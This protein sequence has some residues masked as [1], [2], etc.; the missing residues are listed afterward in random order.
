MIIYVLFKVNYTHRRCNR[1]NLVTAKM[2][3]S[4]EIFVCSSP[5]ML[6]LKQFYLMAK[7]QAWLLHFL[8]QKNKIISIKCKEWK[9]LRCSTVCKFHV[10]CL[11]FVVTSFCQSISVHCCYLVCIKDT[12]CR[13]MFGLRSTEAKVW[14]QLNTFPFP[15]VDVRC[16]KNVKGPL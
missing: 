15:T 13:I 2:F 6:V 14:N 7:S 4:R 10:C 1:L 12:V 5:K 8:L 11:L 3:F 16:H 9:K